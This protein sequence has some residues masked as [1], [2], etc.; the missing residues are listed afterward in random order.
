LGLTVVTLR[1]G[2]IAAGVVR[3][4][5]LLTVIAQ[6]DMTS[7]ERRA[8]SGN[9]AQSAFLNRAESVAVLSQV[10]RAV[11]ADDVGHLLPE[12]LWKLIRGPS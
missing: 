7:Q 12:D 1:T 2:A 5:L 4:N 3:E 10:R 9:I 8:A 6:I 11:E